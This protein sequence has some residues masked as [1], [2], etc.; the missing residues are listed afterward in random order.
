V[1][2]SFVLSKFVPALEAHGLDEAAIQRILVDNP[3]DLLTV[4]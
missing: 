4:R 3:R 2:F 1:P